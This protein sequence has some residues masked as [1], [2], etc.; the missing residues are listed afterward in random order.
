MYNKT[1]GLH[2]LTTLLVTYSSKSSQ[3]RSHRF[4]EGKD[5]LFNMG[6]LREGTSFILFLMHYA[7]ESKQQIVMIHHTTI[8]WESSWSWKLVFSYQT[9]VSHGFCRKDCCMYG[10]TSRNTGVYPTLLQRGGRDRMLIHA[11][12]NY[13]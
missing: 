7:K 5:I 8:Y 2:H 4:V 6:L 10:W 3:H 12:D 9:Y 13:N 1:W 11:Y